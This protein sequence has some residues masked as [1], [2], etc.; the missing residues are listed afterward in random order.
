MDNQLQWVAAAACQNQGMDTGSPLPATVRGRW[1]R[2]RFAAMLL[3][4][5]LA[6]IVAGLTGHWVEAPTIFWDVAAL[7]YLV[8][9]WLVIGRMDP[10]QTRSHA[11]A[12][13]PSRGAT[14]LLILGANVASLAAVAAVVADSH[15]DAG[16][17]ARLGGGLLALASVALSWMLV[18][19]LF[20]LRYARLYYSTGRK[21]GPEV[22]G[23]DFNQ[24]RPPQYTD[25][26]YLATSLGMT[27]QVS[28]TALQN[29]GIRAE[30]LK[31]SLLS[32]LFGTIILAATI[33]LVIG[34]AS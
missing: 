32:Y 18:Q 19:T 25:F 24:S 5:L 15:N 7:T 2:L 22:G 26:A 1:S 8:W 28:D 4:G 33:N 3:A 21:A 9:V 34:L 11:T 10:A 31:H 16:A 27:Y 14:D 6:A 30:A 20:T 23:I 29:H 17:A 13:D 12:E